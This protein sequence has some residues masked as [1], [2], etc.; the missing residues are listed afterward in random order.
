MINRLNILNIWVDAITETHAKE[1]VVAIMN[2]GNRPHSVFA[3]N[4]EKNFSVPKDP[5]L[6][7]IYRKADILLPDG[8]GMVLAT[9]I[10]YRK[11]IGRIPG[12]EFMKTICRLAVQEGKSIFIYGAKED[13]NINACEILQK[14]I[15]G[16]QIA[17]RSNGYVHNSSMSMLIDKINDSGAKVLFLALGSPRQEKWFAQYKDRLKNVVL[18]Q[19]IG[20][21]L[22]AIT[23][24]VK[25]APRLWCR[26][27]LEWLY[28]LLNQPERIGRQKVLPIFAWQ[29][30]VAAIKMNGKLGQKV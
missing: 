3:A 20:G 12:V 17:G 24:N 19:G 27:N 16:L 26:L 28:R 22:D 11:K 6:H 1:M 7:A 14:E 15:P 5:A 21:S 30:M 18:V 4:P 29:V 8:I 25:R 13:I 23:G 2:H 9:R 10:L